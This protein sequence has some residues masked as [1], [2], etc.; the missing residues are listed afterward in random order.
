MT[1]GNHDVNF[2]CGRKN[3]INNSHVWVVDPENVELVEKMK[4]EVLD[5]I[6]VA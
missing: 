5:R 2:E 3:H 4:A 6:K 1:N